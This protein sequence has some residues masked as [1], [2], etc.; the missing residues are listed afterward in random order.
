MSVDVGGTSQA[1]E[2]KAI[3]DSGTSLLG[4]PTEAVSAIA[5]QLGAREIGQGE[6]TVPC[7]YDRLPDFTFSI[8]G[9]DYV[10]TARDYLIADGPLCLLGLV[11][12]DVPSPAGPLWILGDIFMRKY[13]TV[14]DVAEERVGFALANHE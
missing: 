9:K 2:T 14:F 4:A 8:D 1:S 7:D 10:L 12:L 11:G 13:Y 3:V 6:Y 5:A